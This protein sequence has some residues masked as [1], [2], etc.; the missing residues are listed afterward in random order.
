MSFVK[1]QDFYLCK[2][3]QLI[4][5]ET[6]GSYAQFLAVPGTNVFPIPPGFDLKLAAAAPLVY[7]TAYAM[8]VRKAQLK[9]GQTVLVMGAGSGVG[10]AAIQ[11]A[12]HIGATVITT[13]STTDKCQKALHILGA[14]HV[15][16]YSQEDLK[17]RIQDITDKA[18]VDVIIDHVGGPQWQTLLQSLK[19]GGR[20]ITCG[21]TAG[22]KPEI[23]LRHVFFRQLQIMGSTMAS[24]NDMHAAMK[25]IFEGDMTPH[26]D[27]IFPL[28]EA[29]QA[30]Q[31]IEDRKVFGKVL[32]EVS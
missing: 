10:M 2:Y 22:Y 17:S 6:A 9:K 16:Q 4:G 5:R 18:G 27:K 19:N 8:V 23:D 31:Y 13:A 1:R 25:L 30:H 7:Q 21:A 20:L 15:I 14:D 26:I 3:E 32:L 12:K 11:I 29:A 24:Q 28:T